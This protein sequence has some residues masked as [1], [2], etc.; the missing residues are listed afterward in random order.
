[1]SV[2]ILVTYATRYGSTRE[3]AEAVA[4]ELRGKG[5][6]VDIQ[7]AKKVDRLDG[8]DAVVIGAPFYIGSWLKDINAFLKKHQN[9]LGTRRVA[10]FA[11]GPLNAEE[12]DG[13]RPQLDQQ[14][15]KFPWLQPVAVEMFLGKLDPAKLHFPDN[16]LAILPASPLYKKPAVDHRDWDAIRTWAG[17]LADRFIPTVV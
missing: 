13:T 3:V 12:L 5:A 11:L 16:L 7:P 6:R 9:A 8:F 4:S 14:L 15:A 10:V 17:G 2:S 1:M